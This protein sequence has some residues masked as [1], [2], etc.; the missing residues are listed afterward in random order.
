VKNLAIGD[1]LVR[2]KLIVGI[3]AA[4]IL[5]I[6]LVVFFSQG[7]GQNKRE[8]TAPGGNINIG[9]TPIKPIEIFVKQAPSFIEQVLLL[10][11][12][13]I[14]QEKLKLAQQYFEQGFN[15]K[16]VELSTELKK[17]KNT[18]ELTELE[19]KLTKFIKSEYNRY[20]NRALYFF[21]R[22]QYRNAKINII[23]AKEYKNTL[24]L[25]HLEENVDRH[26]R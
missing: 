5:T 24:E 12:D 9:F 18:K 14:F 1:Y 11:K 7:K 22:K 26:L 2:K 10:L 6:M 15:K 16:A 19:K 8:V 13:S 25:R 21:K 3:A 23:Q 4:V 17:I 20:F